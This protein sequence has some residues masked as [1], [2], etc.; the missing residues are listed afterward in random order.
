MKLNLSPGRGAARSDA[1]HRDRPKR[2]V[3]NDP[4]SAA[5]HCARLRR[6]R[7]RRRNMMGFETLGPFRVA[8]SASAVAEHRAGEIL[9][10]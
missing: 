1:P 8:F 9:P 2:G 10:V 5:H 6:A 3:R 4:G 7:E